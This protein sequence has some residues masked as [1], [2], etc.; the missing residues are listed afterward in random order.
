MQHAVLVVAELG[1]GEA[2]L[3][4][5]RLDHDHQVEARG[6]ARRHRDQLRRLDRR[7]A[8]QARADPDLRARIEHQRSLA[9]PP[10]LRGHERLD[11]AGSR[12]DQFERNVGEVVVFV[13]EVEPTEVIVEPEHRRIELA[14]HDPTRRA[15]VLAQIRERS[16]RREPDHAQR[17]V[18]HGHPRPPVVEAEPERPARLDHLD[19]NAVV[20]E[21]GI[22][23]QTGVA[24]RQLPDHLAGRDQ[25]PAALGVELRRPCD[26]LVEADQI[27]IPEQHLVAALDPGTP[28]RRTHVRADQH[29]I[30]RF[31]FVEHVGDAQLETEVSEL[32]PMITTGQRDQ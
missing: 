5:V 16:T 20:R 23:R 1:E 8:R 25:R 19:A 10:K 9:G 32:A 17:L 13:D 3:A 21:L 26:R 22:I 27:G 14:R 15:A 30:A 7:T 12:A 31:E 24:R 11:R 18:D 29:P 6:L 2:R 4:R 28:E